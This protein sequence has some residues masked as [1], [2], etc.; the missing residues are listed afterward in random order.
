MFTSF[1]RRLWCGLLF[2]ALLSVGAW[3]PTQAQ[4]LDDVTI[5]GR[6]ADTN[7]AAIAGAKVT[8]KQDETGAERTVTT[9]GEG[10]FRII[11]LKPGTYTLSISANGF[12]VNSLTNIKTISGQN[13]QLDV[14]LAPQGTIVNVEVSDDTAPAVDTTRTVVGGTVTEREIEGLPNLSRNPLDLIF[15]LGGTAEEPLSTRDLAEDRNRTPGNVVEEAGVFSLSGS[16]AFSNNITIDGL[17]NN[18]D[19][20]AR[21]RFQPSLE[22]ISE[23]QVITNQFSAEYGRASGGR[24]NITTRA[25]T[26]RYRG[27]LFYFFRDEALNANTFRNNSL[28]LK[29]LPLQENNPGF[30]FSGPLYLPYVGNKGPSL[31]NGHNRTFFSATFEYDDVFDTALTNILVP[32]DRNPLFALPAPTSGRTVTENPTGALTT[33][34]LQVGIYNELFTTPLRNKIFNTRVDHRFTD[35][36]DISFGY[37]LGRLRNARQVGISTTTRLSE[38]LTERTRNSDAFSVI[39][40]FTVSPRTVNQ[41]RSQ[42]SRLTPAVSGATK[43]APVILITT[44][45]SSTDPANAAFNT[46]SGTL[47]AG[48]STTSAT[49]RRET[50]FQLTDTLTHLAGPHTLK[51]GADYQHIKSVFVD[52][53]DAS[54]TYNYNSVGDFIRNRLSRYRHNFNTESDQVNNYVGVFFQ[55]EWRFRPNLTFS[56]GVRYERESILKDNNNFGPRVALAYAPRGSQ[57]TVFRLGFGS[58]YNRVLLRTVDDFTFAQKKILFDTNNIP[59]GTTRDNI[60]AQIAQGFPSTL[61]A[62]SPIIQANGTLATSFARRFDPT[63]R[64]PESYQA[65][66]GFEREIGEKFVFEANYTYNKGLHLWREFNANAPVLPAGFPNFAAYL[67]SRGFSNLPVNGVRP[68]LNNNSVDTVVFMAL[69]NNSTTI[70][71]NTTTRTATVNLNAGSSATVL[72]VALAAVRNL[73]PDPTRTQLEQLASIGN[74][75]YHGLILELRRRVSTYKGFRA[76]FRGVYT[77]SKLRDDGIVNTSSAVEPGDFSGEFSR[78]LSDR[79]HRF[80]FSGVFDMPKWLGKLRF[81]PLLRYGSSAPFNLSAGGIDRNLDDVNNDRPNFSGDIN[82]IVT[83]RSGEALN[84]GITTA[85]LTLPTI[86]TV[87]NLPRNVGKGPG[88]FLFDINVTR[89]IRFTKTLRLRPTVEFSNVLNRTAFSFGSDFINFATNFTA[90]PTFLVPSRS[91]R[92]RQIR[93]GFRLDF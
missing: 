83:R 64:I 30:S 91:Y 87:G 50:R 47:I 23:V 27:R 15:T 1:R 44:R 26:N 6:V 57:R 45:V 53:A 59:A 37:Q 20:A 51:F 11:E 90:D 29:R 28:G 33:P 93:A 78:S 52:L 58:F 39:D 75:V 62:D 72:N 70:P 77:F 74:S 38:A 8:A 24:V 9:D 67:M 68:L 48:N 69:D 61:T 60:L 10:R 3:R 46:S 76:S 86:G 80:A 42:Y 14:P 54:G 71:V 31:Y 4:D 41:I 66:A 55:D 81:S 13:V 56:Y 12:A 36:H 89:E 18:D 92:P 32:L 19:R 5:S 22:A 2:V 65:N 17:D 16:P 73:R 34:P 63:I 25:G 40:N 85:N 49:D 82:A 35:S 79:R 21:E 7:N 84:P 88:L 43:T